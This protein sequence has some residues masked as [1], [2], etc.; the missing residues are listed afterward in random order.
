MV[1]SRLG[2][3]QYLCISRYRFGQTKQTLQNEHLRL[4]KGHCKYT[5]N[6]H[7]MNKKPIVC[8]FPI[9]TLTRL[10]RE[11]FAKLWIAMF[12]G[13]FGDTCRLAL[14]SEQ[15]ICCGKALDTRAIRRSPFVPVSLQLRSSHALKRRR[16]KKKKWHSSC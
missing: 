13:S 3:F 6:C 11:Q 16:R 10:S 12:E 5:E 2:G 7:S 1:L 15:L 14:K 8:L 4:E 9:S